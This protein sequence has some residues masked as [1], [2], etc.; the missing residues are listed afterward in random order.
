MS[1]RI[2]IVKGPVYDY[3]RPLIG[4]GLLTS[5]GRGRIN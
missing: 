2:E 5:T 3:L 4:D 1:S